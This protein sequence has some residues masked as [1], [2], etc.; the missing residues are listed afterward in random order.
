MFTKSL[1]I[2]LLAAH[3][4]ADPVP[5]PAPQAGDAQSS[6][7]AAVASATSL[8]NILSDIP[9]LPL[10][11]A[12]VLATAVPTGVQ[13]SAV[14]CEIATATP[15]WYQSLPADVRSAFSS[16]QSAAQ[17]WYSAHSSDLGVVSTGVALPVAPC[18]ATGTGSA[19]AGAGAGAGAGAATSAA[20]SGGAASDTSKGAAPRPTGAVVASLAGAVGVLGLMVAL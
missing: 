12:S 3:S 5:A 7:D 8:L 20:G 2:A 16:Y 4:L 17:S 11:V 9:T 18:M 15:G 14:G 10:S 1:L 13:V 19:A 6:L